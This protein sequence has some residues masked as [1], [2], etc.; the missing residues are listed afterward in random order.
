ME[1]DRQYI[2]DENLFDRATLTAINS[3]KR[4]LKEQE[5]DSATRLE[6]QKTERMVKVMQRCAYNERQCAAV[7][8]NLLRNVLFEELADRT[9]HAAL[10]QD[11]QRHII[12]SD[13]KNDGMKHADLVA[14]ALQKQLEELCPFPNVAQPHNVQQLAKALEAAG[15]ALDSVGVTNNV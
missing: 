11:R 5:A 2:P 3:I 12:E 1:T 8:E 9:A 7:R 4:A 10:V 6:L 15:A 13:P 14:T